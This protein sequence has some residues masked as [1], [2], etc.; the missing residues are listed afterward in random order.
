MPLQYYLPRVDRYNIKNRCLQILA[1]LK[2]VFGQ[3]KIT[4]EY[5]SLILLIGF[6]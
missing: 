4:L 6:T 1:T 5:L 3:V 2:I